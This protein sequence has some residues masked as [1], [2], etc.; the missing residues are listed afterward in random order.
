MRSSCILAVWV[1][2][3]PCGGCGT[4]P[5]HVATTGKPSARANE[6][7]GSVRTATATGP[8]PQGKAFLDDKRVVGPHVEWNREVSTRTGGTILCRVSSAGPFAVTVITGQAYKRSRVAIRIR[9]ANR[10]SC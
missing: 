3:L 1:I 2:V 7:A 8:R 6:P 5:R 10:T 4:E 9:S